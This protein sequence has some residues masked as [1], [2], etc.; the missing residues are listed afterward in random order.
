M[1]KKERDEALSELTARIFSE[2]VENALMDEV[3]AAHQEIARARTI[4]DVCH[5]RCTEAHVPGPSNSESRAA[6]PSSRAVSPS[7]IEG[8][9]N[10]KSPAGT[11]SPVPGQDGNYYLA[12]SVCNRQVAS[13]RYA[14]HLSGCMNLNNTRR[15]AARSA[16]AKS[17]LASEA[18]RSASP[19]VTPENGHMS[20]DHKTT[21]NATKS[22]GKS[23]A[24]RADGAEAANRKRPASPSVSPA[25][26]VKKA[27]VGGSPISRVKADPELP[28]S[29]I[30][31][32]LPLPNSQTKIPSKLRD[33][34][35]VSTQYDRQSSSPTP[36]HIS[37]PAHSVSTL[38]SVAPNQSPV[39]SASPLKKG[40]KPNG[41]AALPIPVKRLSPPRPPPPVIRMVE[42]DYLI[43]V[44]GDE[45][46]S[47]T[48]TDSS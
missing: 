16:T 35:F 21:G 48:D 22:K 14:Q 6:G 29:P 47:S 13:N 3:L 30:P 17:K 8:I 1:P 33:S 12:C 43:D 26:K 11:G 5:T 44:E 20:D 25:K 19:Y 46:G 40:K 10:N 28:A 41:K 36:T 7:A 38:A 15:G 39:L 2:M 34:S 4:C 24:K 31:A 45:T 32:T 18:G 37:S 23:K 42:P 9:A 27:K